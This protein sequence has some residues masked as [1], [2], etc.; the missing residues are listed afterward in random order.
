LKVKYKTKDPGFVMLVVPGDRRIASNKVK[1]VL[2]AKEI[3]FASL[4][5]VATLTEGIESGGV[6]PFG[7]LFGLP[8]LV[9]TSLL[10]NEKIIF[11]AGDRRFS[12]AMFVKDYLS[13][14]APMQKDIVE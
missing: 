12:I 8:V 6:P 5:E 3:R 4:E 2:G 10:T 1:A 14:V 11:N 13:L 9:D 7:N